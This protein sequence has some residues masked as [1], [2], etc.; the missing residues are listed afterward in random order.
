[1]YKK[2]VYIKT[3]L[4][5]L[6]LRNR[7]NQITPMWLWGSFLCRSVTSIVKSFLYAS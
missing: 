5:S 7:N 3:E 2:S 1:M 4:S 6:L